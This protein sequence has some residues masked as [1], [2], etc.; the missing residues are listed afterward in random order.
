MNRESGSTSTPS[1]VLAIDP[2]QAK[3]G[4]AVV[5]PDG[6]CLHREIVAPSE[7][8]RRVEALLPRYGFGVIVLGDRTSSAGAAVALAGLEGVTVALV[9]EHRSTEEA[10][11]LYLA[12][13]PAR[14]LGRL[15]PRG[16]RTPPGPVD[17]YAAWVLGRRYQ[18]RG[19]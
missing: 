5:A 15:L 4:L 3:S 18:A 8:R 16:L 14:G 13:N 11:R 19:V 10:R 9:D 6:S 12:G 7:M 17:D 1:P 2:G